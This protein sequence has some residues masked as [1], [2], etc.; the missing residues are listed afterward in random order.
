MS[1]SKKC[2]SCV[3][4]RRKLRRVLIHSLQQSVRNRISQ[5][6]ALKVIY[7]HLGDDEVFSVEGGQE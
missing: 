2:S 1:V 3:E 7:Y 4:C 6:K 5:Q